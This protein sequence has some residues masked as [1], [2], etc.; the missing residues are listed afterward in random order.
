MH[1]SGRERVCA[2]RRRVPFFPTNSLVRRLSLSFSLSLSLAKG[3]KNGEKST[4]FRRGI[5]DQREADAATA[6]AAAAT[7]R[8]TIV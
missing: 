2:F 4:G 3:E 8:C 7:S 6:T 5:A 1:R